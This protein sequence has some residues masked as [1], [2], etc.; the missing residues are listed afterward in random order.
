MSSYRVV[1]RVL[2]YAK[3][4]R[5]MNSSAQET[6]VDSMPWEQERPPS[7]YAEVI[8]NGRLVYRTRTKQ[9]NPSPYWNATGERFIRD[10][11]KARLVVV[12]RDERDRENGER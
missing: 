10:W 12:I 5:C 9:I 3:R 2:H 4:N 11:S 1:G 6:V 7:A 8:L